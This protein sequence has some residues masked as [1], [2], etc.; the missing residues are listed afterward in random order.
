MS[1]W[2]QQ[3]S[4]ASAFGFGASIGALAGR[5]VFNAAAGAVSSV[6]QTV[7]GKR[8]DRQAAERDGRQEPQ[9][10]VGTIVNGVLLKPGH[11]AQM[12]SDSDPGAAPASASSSASAAASAASASAAAAAVPVAPVPAPAR[13]SHKSRL[14]VA[15]IVWENQRYVLFKWRPPSLP[16]DRWEWSNEAGSVRLAPP[17]LSGFFDDEGVEDVAVVSTA[18]GVLAAAPAPNLPYEVVIEPGRTDAEGWMYAIDFPREYRER[19]FPLACVR[20]RQW[21][22]IDVMTD[23]MRM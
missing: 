1:R 10:P 8:T 2:L 11:T 22:R 6:A 18:E 9:Q 14:P 5:A 12:S 20:R 21:R 4:D 3:A 16:T 13:S 7:N 17:L 15:P 19:N 23:D